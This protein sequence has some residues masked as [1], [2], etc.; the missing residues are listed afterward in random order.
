MNTENFAENDG[1]F[2][3]LDLKAKFEFKS[4]TS[5]GFRIALGRFESTNIGAIQVHHPCSGHIKARVYIQLPKRYNDMR[6]LVEILQAAFRKLEIP[7]DET[8]QLSY[9]ATEDGLEMFQPMN[10][11]GQSDRV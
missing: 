5:I 3:V 2:E 7:A 9:D 11:E 1:T 8:Y 10:R 6:L 4:P